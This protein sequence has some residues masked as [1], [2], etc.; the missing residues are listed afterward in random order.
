MGEPEDWVQSFICMCMH[1]HLWIGNIKPSFCPWVI[2][3]QEGIR[4]MDT[5]KTLRFLEV[6]EERT[7]E[8][9][10]SG[11]QWKNSLL[12]KPSVKKAIKIQSTSYLDI[13]TTIKN[14]SFLSKLRCI[15]MQR[16]YIALNSF[17]F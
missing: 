2:N 4:H 6:N 9:N 12:T 5:K 8:E 3:L 11:F 17:I 10:L 7:K 1:G 14:S 16:K 15:W 13:S